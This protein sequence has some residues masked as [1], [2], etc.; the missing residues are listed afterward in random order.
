M[1]NGRYSASPG[2][3]KYLKRKIGAK[4]ERG[5]AL[6]DP[7]KT[8]CASCWRKALLAWNLT[9]SVRA[10]NRR[11]DPRCAAMRTISGWRPLRHGLPFRW[12]VTSTDASAE[13]FRS[14]AV[15]RQVRSALDPGYAIN[16]V[17]I[18]RLRRCVQ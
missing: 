7:S 1:E 14:L 2:D 12:M 6:S 10:R 18:A 3:G 9:G 13:R 17:R 8:Q 11:R 16:R 15:L 4:S 5:G